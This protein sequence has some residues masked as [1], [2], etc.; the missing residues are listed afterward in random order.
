MARVDLRELAPTIFTTF[1]PPTGVEH[2][3]FN[4]ELARYGAAL[5][6][7]ALVAGKTLDDR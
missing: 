7:A 6:L 2:G 3:A 5:S 1:S 4:I